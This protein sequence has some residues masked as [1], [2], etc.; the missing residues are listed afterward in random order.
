[1][2]SRPLVANL[3]Y[4]GRHT[5]GQTNMKKSIVAFR[6]FWKA[7]RND[8]IFEQYH[9]LGH[10]V[11]YCDRNCLHFD[12]PSLC[13]QGKQF[14]KVVLHYTASHLR[15]IYPIFTTIKINFTTK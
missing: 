5:E 7:P 8:Q 10:D 15:G 2:K 12:V 11:V 1:M 9:I 6:N 3:F 14:V 4:A 13:I